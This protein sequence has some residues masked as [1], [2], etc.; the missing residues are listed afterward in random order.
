MEQDAYRHTAQHVWYRIGRILVAGDVI[1]VCVH[2][3]IFVRALV[4]E[5]SELT[6]D[7]GLAGL[8]FVGNSVAVLD[9][10]SGL[11]DYIFETEHCTVRNVKSTSCF[12]ISC[13]TLYVDCYCTRR[14]C[15]TR[16]DT[17]VR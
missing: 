3:A 15:A 9:L 8:H 7:L 10:L 11:H 5:W 14:V 2:F 1:L 12:L 17:R 16:R 6:L 4:H 13:F